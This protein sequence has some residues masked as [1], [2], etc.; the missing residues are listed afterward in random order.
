MPGLGDHQLRVTYAQSELLAASLGDLAEALNDVCLLAEGSSPAARSLLAGFVPVVIDPSLLDRWG[1]VRAAAIAADL[2][3]AGRLLRATTPEGHLLD[4][5]PIASSADVPQREDGRPLTLGERRAL[6]RRPSRAALDR[7]MRD[8]H[9]MVARLVLAN[10]RI[11]EDDVVR[12]AAYRPARPEI[13]FEIAKA[14]SHHARPR[15]AIVLNPGS[16]PAVSVPLLGLLIRPEL[17]DVARAADLPA[18][19]RATAQ[20]LWELRPPLP[21]KSPPEL[22]H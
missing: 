4:R 6:A 21:P 11:T 19:V 10:P 2:M 3:A 12:M 17:A 16:P 20:D 8:P 22:K 7:L 13:V 18:V 1:S 15:K 5:E 14:W 9:P